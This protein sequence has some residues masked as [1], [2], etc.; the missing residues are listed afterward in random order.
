MW[1]FW[2]RRHLGLWVCLL[3]GLGSLE[4]RPLLFLP[5][6]EVLGVGS[7]SHLWSLVCWS[8]YCQI[9]LGCRLHICNSL[10]FCVFVSSGWGGML[11]VLQ[12]DLR[13]QTGGRGSHGESVMLDYNL[14]LM[15]KVRSFVLWWYQTTWVVLVVFGGLL[16]YVSECCWKL[17]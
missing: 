15:C 11:S 10:W 9:L 1:V 2:I 7:W 4:C 13:N 17:P 12:K 16:G 3:I 14:L 8:G 5:W 6:I